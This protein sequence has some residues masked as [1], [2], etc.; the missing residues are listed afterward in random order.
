MAGCF[1]EL[2][3]KLTERYGPSEAATQMVDVLLLAREHGPTTSSWP[4]GARSPRARTTVVP[5]R[6][7]PAAP[8]GRHRQ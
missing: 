5:S 1:D 3:A 2:W 4:S 6:F 8:S 7:S